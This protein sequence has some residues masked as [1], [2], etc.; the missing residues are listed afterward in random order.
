MV[1]YNPALSVALGCNTAV[2]YIGSGRNAKATMYYISDYI[3]KNNL[4]LYNMVNVCT[5]AIEKYSNL[6]DIQVCN[7][8]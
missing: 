3:T 6:Q 7:S 5:A 8:K 2:E 1:P 4:A